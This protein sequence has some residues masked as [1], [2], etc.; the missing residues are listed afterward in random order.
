MLEDMTDARMLRFWARVVPGDDGCWNWTAARNKTGYGV[1]SI[2]HRPVLAHRL[3]H[4]L[5]HGKP[6]PWGGQSSGLVCHRCDNPACVRPDH[7]FVGDHQDNYDDMAAKGR[8]RHAEPWWRGERSP[9]ARWTDDQVRAMRRARARGE[10]LH[11]I[12]KDFDTSPG[13]VSRICNRKR[14]THI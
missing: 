9:H 12:A 11:K 14:W 10:L 1:F 6:S 7:L 8:V 5:T 3:V 4:F 13:S 2:K